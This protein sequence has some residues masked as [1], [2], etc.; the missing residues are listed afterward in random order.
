MEI[1]RDNGDGKFEVLGKK[2]VP[3]TLSTNK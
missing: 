1:W 3:V 2:P